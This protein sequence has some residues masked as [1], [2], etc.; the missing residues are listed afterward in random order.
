M[1]QQWKEAYPGLLGKLLTTTMI[2]MSRDPEQ[3]S[4]SALYAAVSP[5][6]E[7]K[8]WN[9]RYFTD[10]SQLGERSKQASD[11]LLGDN[12]WK[13]SGKLIRDVVGEDAMVDWN[14]S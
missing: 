7:E 11:P 14:S 13:L 3:G 5:E 6:V 10:P 1:Q 9:G 4:Y 2:T 8:D 12:L